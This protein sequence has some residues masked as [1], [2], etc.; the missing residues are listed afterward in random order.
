[1]IKMIRP[2]RRVRSRAKIGCPIVAG[3]MVW[4]SL[5]ECTGLCGTIIEVVVAY[6]G[7]GEG[8][9]RLRKI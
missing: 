3:T 4:Q 1:M 9:S 8:F 5:F 7:G 2:R 6:V